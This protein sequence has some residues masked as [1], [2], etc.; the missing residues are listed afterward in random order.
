MTKAPNMGL[1]VFAG[2]ATRTPKKNQIKLYVIYIQI[3]NNM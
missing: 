2:G 1:F 3:L